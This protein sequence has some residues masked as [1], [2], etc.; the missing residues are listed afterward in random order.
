MLSVNVKFIANELVPGLVDGPY[1][2]DNGATVRDLLATCENR[3][4]ANVP[5]KNFK[6][7]YPLFNGKPLT[8]DSPITENGTLHLCRIVLGG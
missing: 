7:M 2:I 1:D 8:L 5:E 4:G 6:S 3:C